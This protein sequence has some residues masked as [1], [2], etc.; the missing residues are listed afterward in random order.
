MKKRKDYTEGEDFLGDILTSIHGSPT[1][2]TQEGT[3]ISPMLV[4]LIN[5]PGSY[6]K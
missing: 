2:N 1:F 4:G 3:S 5:V 6:R